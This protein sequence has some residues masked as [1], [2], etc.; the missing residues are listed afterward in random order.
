MIW[1]LVAIYIMMLVFEMPALIKKRW[2]KE[3]TVFS[4][5]FIISVY[6]GMVQFYDWP[7]FDPLN[8]LLPLAEKSHLD[9]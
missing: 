5:L 9:F 1:L 2:Y 4:V 7:F 6:M 3:I 8:T